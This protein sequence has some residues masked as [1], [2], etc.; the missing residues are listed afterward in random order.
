MSSSIPVVQ[1]ALASS[2]HW[3]APFNYLGRSL[4]WRSRTLQ[5]RNEPIYVIHFLQYHLAT[6][7][8]SALSG[9]LPRG[10]CSEHG[11]EGDQ[12][13]AH[14]GGEGELGRLAA[15]DQLGV[16]GFQGAFVGLEAGDGG[17]VEGAAG[18]GRL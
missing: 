11:V 8:A 5:R 12:H 13:G 10:F 14:E 18:R 9:V 3:Q 1:G 17:H 2:D 15:C 4:A 6:V 16:A 7:V